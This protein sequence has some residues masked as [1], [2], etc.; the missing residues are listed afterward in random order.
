[1]TAL[2]LETRKL[3]RTRLGPLILGLAAV[4][5]IWLTFVI[6][7]RGQAP[8]GRLLA[9]GAAETLSMFTMLGGLVAGLIAVRVV[10]NDA[11]TGMDAYLVGRGHGALRLFGTK[12]ALVAILV[13]A[14]HL[15]VFGLML[16]I[17]TATGLAWSPSLIA[18][19]GP[20]LIVL[21][22]WS[23]A[24]AATHVAVATL[25]SHPAATVIVGLLGGVVASGL[26]F[27]GAPAIGW[28]LP[29]GL[30]AAASPVAALTMQHA[31]AT[32]VALDP[33]RWL[34]AGLALV[35]AGCWIAVAFAAAARKDRRR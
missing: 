3:R 12:V 7:A 21:V 19:L 2:A 1:M 15:A 30:T 13:T 35:A 28:A 33:A 5:V 32:D 16:L 26:P 34:T 20:A 10:R 24:L 9:F 25:V 6:T 17:G 31:G 27:M 8:E 11:D 4:Q 22:A 14:Y 29:W 23:A 18:M